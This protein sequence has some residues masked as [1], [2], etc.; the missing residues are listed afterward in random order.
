VQQELHRDQI[1][2]IQIYHRCLNE[3][4][5]LQKIGFLPVIR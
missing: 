5:C 3:N 1:R 2:Q 4:K